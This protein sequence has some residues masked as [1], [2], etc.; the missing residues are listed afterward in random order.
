MERTKN[1]D[2]RTRT[3]RQGLKIKDQRTMSR[4]QRPKDKDQRNRTKEPR[5]KDHDQSI[6]DTQSQVQRLSKLNTFDPG[7]V[8]YILCF[9]SWQVMLTHITEHIIWRGLN[10]KKP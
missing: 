7:V 3:N 4:G 1:N 10:K 9:E 2:Q 8:R 5:S 6:K